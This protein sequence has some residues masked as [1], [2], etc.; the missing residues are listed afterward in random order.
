MSFTLACSLAAESDSIVFDLLIRVRP[1]STSKIQGGPH[2]LDRTDMPWIL[3]R[4]GRHEQPFGGPP[5]P[6]DPIRALVEHGEDRR[7]LRL[8]IL[9]MIV[10]FE[11]VVSG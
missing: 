10:S 6:D 5:Q 7:L 3:F 2:R 11:A 1:P 4:L 8:V 9:A